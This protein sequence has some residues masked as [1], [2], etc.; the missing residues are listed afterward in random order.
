VVAE[1]ELVFI[2][3]GGPKARPKAH[4]SSGWEN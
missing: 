3:L 4:D 2:S 1:Q